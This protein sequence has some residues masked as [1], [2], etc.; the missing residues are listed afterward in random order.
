MPL[1]FF[2][3]ICDKPIIPSKF[4][5]NNLIHDKCLDDYLENFDIPTKEDYKQST[6][7]SREK[8]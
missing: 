1:P 7:T 8:K 6:T 4:M 2:C 3:A 5:K